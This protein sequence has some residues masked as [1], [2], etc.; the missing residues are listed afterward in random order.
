MVLKKRSIALNKSGK[1]LGAIS[2]QLQVPRATVQTIVCKYKVHGTVL[3]LP[4][5]G[6]KRMLSPAAGRVKSQPRTTKKQICQEFE[7]A[8]TQVL[9]ST[10]KRVLHIHGLIGY[11]ARK[12][13][14][15][16]KRHLKARLIFAADHMDKDETFWRKVLWSDETKIEKR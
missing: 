3:S 13:P 9:V 12:K 1:S 10:V 8:E 11:R 6:R 14:L 7:A 15:L 5:S 16:Q 2:K 4:Q